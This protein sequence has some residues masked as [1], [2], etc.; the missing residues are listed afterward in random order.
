MNMKG[1]VAA[2]TGG[3]GVLGQA[4]A[5]GL[6][7]QGVHVYILNR[8]QADAQSMKEAFADKN[9]QISTIACDV[10][11]EASVKSAVQEIIEKSGKIDI[12]INGAGGNQRG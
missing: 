6:A 11:N 7:E 10:L 12:L 1:K 2:I 9:L 4:F 5:Q 8:N 3:S